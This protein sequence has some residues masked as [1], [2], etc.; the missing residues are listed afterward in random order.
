MTFPRIKG[1]I[2][3]DSVG[4]AGV[5][6]PGHLLITAQ[7]CR[8]FVQADYWDGA[9]FAPRGP[10]VAPL[11]SFMGSGRFAR[12]IPSTDTP[13]LPRPPREKKKR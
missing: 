13:L 9:V 10:D 8:A 5:S 12:M 6:V 11:L 2:Q 4:A 3:E 1:V 7:M